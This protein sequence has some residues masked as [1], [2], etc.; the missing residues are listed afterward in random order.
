MDNQT[1]E[2]PDPR[3][4]QA[5]RLSA[6]GDYTAAMELFSRLIHEKKSLPEAHL[7][8]GVA[9]IRQHLYEKAG[10]YLRDCGQ[11]F[12]EIH[13][14]AA[15]AYA[16]AGNAEEE[17]AALKRVVRT[18]H[19]QRV[20]EAPY[21]SAAQ[22]AVS[23]KDWATAYEALQ[24]LFEMLADDLSIVT[25]LGN[26]CREMGWK[27]QA[28]AYYL[29]AFELTED[30][31]VRAS[32]H[33]GLAGIYKDAGEQDQAL[34]HFGEAHRLLQTSNSGSNRIM[35][36][37]YHHATDLR[38]F[39]Q[40]CRE[41][42]AAF[43]HYTPHFRHPRQRLD[44]E[45]AKTGLRIGFMS[46]D[47]KAHAL[48]NL[49]LEPFK[50]LREVS[51]H[52]FYIYSEVEE[53]LEDEYTS[54]YREAVHHWRRTHGV[55]N[56]Q[57]AQMIY[58]D[59]IDVLVDLAGHTALNRLPV[60]GYKAAPVQAGWVSGMMTPSAL[61]TVNYFMTDQWMRPPSA[62]DVCY[63]QMYDLP[64]AY[65]YFPITD[66]PDI[67]PLPADRAGHVTFGS[68]NNPCKLHDQTIETWAQILRK[69]PQSRLV[70]KVL[71]VGTPQ[72]IKNQMLA[73]GVTPDRLDFVGALPGAD[74]V[75]RYYTEKIDI[76]LDT[77]PC[78][79]CLTSAEALWMGC[80]IIT[81]V[82]DTFLHRQT[83]TIYNQIGLTDLGVDTPEAYIDKTVELARDRPRL[84]ELRQTLRDR[85]ENAPIR[86][87]TLVAKG[88]TD[89]CEHFWLDWCHSRESLWGLSLAK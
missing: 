43:L 15:S 74:D 32:L 70:I 20:F 11:D 28:T 79:G 47:W 85:M 1:D 83:W 63:E 23:R 86:Q 49:L 81:L 8:I 55:S 14:N 75:M 65:C 69:V 45:R 25:Q 17:Y 16:S 87:P 13:M 61:E 41:Y 10:D 58:D 52:Q 29:K 67:A 60:F 33:A 22:A 27:K 4:V 38:R 3:L 82:G 62:A 31:T 64:S 42:S 76:V 68:F 35:F 54:S 51:V 9:L 57:V 59:Q 24:L 53:G 2:Q 48:T 84:R 88:V 89:A 73:L 66:A 44:P 18:R 30:P 71:S 72:R 77:W 6:S 78:T 21:R 37:Q 56:Q 36:A 26:V 34:N 46:G 80:P 39:Y 5:K 12:A 50:R 7:G 40:L 19:R